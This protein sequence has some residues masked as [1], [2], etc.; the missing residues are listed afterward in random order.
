MAKVVSECIVCKGPLVKGQT[1]CGCGAY[2]Y[3]GSIHKEYSDKSVT[4]A[5]VRAKRGD[6][7]IP[8]LQTGPWDKVFGKDWKTGECGM[9]IGSSNLVGG[10]PGAG[11]STV[12]IQMADSAVDA[13]G[14]D[15]LYI[16]AEEQLEQIDV[17]AERLGVKNLDKIRFVRAMASDVDVAAILQSRLFGF[18]IVDSITAIAAEDMTMQVQIAHAVKMHLDTMKSK[19]PAVLICQINKGGDFS[20]LQAL[21]HEVDGTYQ[22]FKGEDIGEKE[23][24]RV[25]ATEKNRNG[26]VES[27]KFRMTE[28]G[29]IWFPEEKDEE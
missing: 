16:A 8:R 17:R 11:K 21:Q 27:M 23:P 5:E 19:C 1:K 28:Q 3:K 22:L 13:T 2:N 10:E 12:L 24:L 26:E 18:L 29:L 7:P 25:F 20:G 4:L 6:K 14:L 9:L 15:S